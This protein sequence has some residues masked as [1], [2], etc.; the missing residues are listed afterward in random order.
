MSN[1]GSHNTEWELTPH[2]VR[3]QLASGELLL[4]DCR[5]EAERAVASIDGSM[6]VPMDQLTARLEELR[7]HEKKPIA[8]HCHLGVRSLRVTAFLRQEGFDNARSLAGGIDRW[9]VEIDPAVPRY[10]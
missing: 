9:S 7:D 1:P 4:I 2:Q 3:D 6:H 10:S 5:T 8:V